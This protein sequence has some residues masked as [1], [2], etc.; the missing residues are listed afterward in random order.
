MS[1]MQTE[2]ATEKQIFFLSYFL[3][4]EALFHHD[5]QSIP[6]ALAIPRGLSGGFVTHLPLHSLLRGKDGQEF[7]ALGF[8][9]C[10]PVHAW[11]WPNPKAQF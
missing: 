4:D 2:Q 9:M 1:Q 11:E 10:A 8:N 7:A 6:D 3:S 5:H